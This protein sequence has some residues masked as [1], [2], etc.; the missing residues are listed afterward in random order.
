M[1]PNRLDL[2]RVAKYFALTPVG[3]AASHC[4]NGYDKDIL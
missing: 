4:P 2:R 3:I 1:T